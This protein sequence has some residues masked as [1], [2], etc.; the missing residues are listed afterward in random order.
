M[1]PPPNFRDVGITL[2]LLNPASESDDVSEFNFDSAFP[3]RPLRKGTNCCSLLQPGLLLRSGAFD[4]APCGWRDI[5]SPRTIVNLREFSADETYSR[6]AGEAASSHTAAVKAEAKADGVGDPHCS[7][8]KSE[9]F[10]KLEVWNCSAANDQEKYDVRNCEV[11][12]WI[13]GVITRLLESPGSTD[14]VEG[15]LSATAAACSSESQGLASAVAAF[16]AEYLAAVEGLEK[17]LS[18][19]GLALLHAISPFRLALSF[20]LREALCVCGPM[21]VHCR[22]GRDR[23]GIM[24]AAVL[25]AICPTV[26]GSAAEERLRWL[27]NEDFKLSVEPAKNDARELFESK[28]LCK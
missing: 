19:E 20:L 24:V 27:I 8:N 16:L 22:F 21:L 11:R 28:W 7:E 23:T 18:D 15:R 14:H 9:N 26:T 17:S 6:L 2:H 4:S 5:G 12:D 10:I 1:P 13:L 3:S 25:T